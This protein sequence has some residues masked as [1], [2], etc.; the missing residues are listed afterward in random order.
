MPWSM[1]DL[2]PQLSWTDFVHELALLLK[3]HDIETP[4]YLVGGAVRDAYLRRAVT[5]IDIAVDGDAIALARRITD[6]LDGDIYVMDRERGVA[7]V[8]VTR[9]RERICVDFARIRGRTL[10]EDLRDRDFTMNAMAVDLL[11]D[12]SVLI[13]PLG[14]VSDL[15]DKVLRY[16]SPQSLT[17]DP[18][19]MLRA[20]RL[21]AQFNLKMR[22]EI[23]AEV[24][25][26]SA[27]LGR[28]S[29]ERVRDELFKLLS[30]E[31]AARAL[32]VLLHM[33]LL[34]SLIKRQSDQDN[35]DLEARFRSESWNSS[36]AVVERMSALLKAVSA[37]RT[38]N[39]AAAFDLGMLVIQLDRFRA[40]L[41][42]HITQQYG[43][44]RSHAELLILA[45]LMLDR[46]Q[47]DVE[48]LL[49]TLK[50]TG[51]EARKMS[52]AIANY[53]KIRSPQTW[54]ALDQH[55]FWYELRE[56]G[57]DVILLASTHYL[58]TEGSELK[59]HDWLAHVDAVTTL[60]DAY[61]NR[62]DEIVDPA[63]LLDG[64][65]IR[66]LCQLAPG[67]LVGE[68]LTAL[69]EAQV[70][71]AVQTADEAADFVGKRAASRKR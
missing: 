20:V 18:V 41:Q 17:D 45:A 67:P 25:V 47:E 37:R 7:R 49:Q 40:Q 69:R 14:G 60:L 46:A 26:L 63:L 16:C 43:K 55:R 28:V 23:T 61:F 50:L 56:S 29:G 12:L 35:E 2:R 8:F 70:A 71:G 19:R 54:T 30:S 65:E 66:R 36:L 59:Q 24:R 44:S 48:S 6:W 64:N 42:R 62:Y 15:R 38:D 21:S 51:A 68:L 13:D 3:K 4:L 10:E 58:A 32:R 53:T 27:E 1:D 11:G 33:N 9:Q 57:I 31:R 5:D 39:T 34:Q 22:P 52:R